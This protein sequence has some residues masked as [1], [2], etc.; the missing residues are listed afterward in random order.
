MSLNEFIVEDAAL[1][2]SHY[3]ALLGVEHSNERLFYPKRQY[4]VVSR[5]ESRHHVAMEG[6]RVAGAHFYEPRK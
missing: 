5:H 2:W 4:R 1:G 3:Q 6:Q